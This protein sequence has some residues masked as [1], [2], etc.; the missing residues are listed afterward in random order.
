LYFLSVG[1]AL[2]SQYGFGDLIPRNVEEMS[3]IVLFFYRKDAKFSR[4]RKESLRSLRIAL[5]LCG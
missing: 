4:V 1:G 3:A 2:A 5:R